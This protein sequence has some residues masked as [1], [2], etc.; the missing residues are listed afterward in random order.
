MVQ[1]V[2]GR[3]GA[4]RHH[5]AAAVPIMAANATVADTAPG[6]AAAAAAADSDPVPNPVSG[7]SLT[8]PFPSPPFPLLQ[9]LLTV[10]LGSL[11]DELPNAVM[12]GV[13][14]YY[15]LTTFDG[16]ELTTRTKLALYVL[17]L[18][19][20]GVLSQELSDC[21]PQRSFQ[22]HFLLRSDPT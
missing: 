13:L 10:F 5:A 16:N 22:A 20:R 2:A 18:M 4:N 11:I 15:G 14:L 1:S 12:M 6:D 8:S 19:P 9:V 7:C 17:R 21:R 3:I